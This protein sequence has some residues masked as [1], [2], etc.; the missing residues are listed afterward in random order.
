[1]A[2]DPV[3]H[4]SGTATYSTQFEVPEHRSRVWLDLG[5]VE[6]MAHVRVNG[7]DLGILWK[8]PYRVDVTE[9]VNSGTNML[10]IAVVN[11]W[12]NRLIGD[13][14]LPEDAER[15]KSGRLVSWPD[16]VL[17]GRSSPTGRRSFVTFPLWKK[18][19]PLRASGLLGPVSLHLPVAVHL[20]SSRSGS[21]KREEPPPTSAAAHFH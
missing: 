11:L 6:V 16:W 7:R 12:V 14:A 1:V 20:A 3:R 10:E 18:E 5:R 8:P 21:R 13:A 4:F 15:D 2:D 17:E 19:E 9:A